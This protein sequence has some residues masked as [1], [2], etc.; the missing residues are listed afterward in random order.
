MP[1]HPVSNAAANA[2]TAG[3]LAENVTRFTRMLRAAGFAVGPERTIA[4]LDALQ[5]LGLAHRVRVHA[6]LASVL[7]D[8]H[9]DQPLFDAAFDA[10]WCAPPGADAA[11]PTAARDPGVPGRRAPIAASQRLSDALSAGVARQPAAVRDEDERVVVDVALGVSTRERLARRDFESMSAEEF[12]AATRLA[13]E[14]P[15]LLVPV[16]TR[17]RI[18]AARGAIDLH[19]VLRDS[20]RDPFAARLPRRR[21]QRRLPPLVVLCDV[22]GSMQRYSR[23]F[24]H[25]VHAMIR[26]HRQV[27][28]LTL[29]TRLT[30]I[31]HALQTRD[32]DDALAAVGSQVGDW[33][34]GTRLGPCL[35]E[36][37]RRWARRLL[38]GRST[39]LLLT[40]GLDRDDSG[41]LSFEAR[42]LRR[43]ARRTLWLNPLL[44]FAGFEPRAAGIRA[45]L[46]HVDEFLPAHDLDSLADLSNLLARRGERLR[47]DRH[48]TGRRTRWN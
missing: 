31:T 37:N 30:R 29:G 45:L 21:P 41:V 34:G 17:R 7:L 19:R 22:S 14:L 23:V 47:R 43:Y 27:E 24:L 44:R 6:A 3:H 28:A 35:R 33:A 5:L 12:R 32:V 1:P 10:F 8:R 42:R 15:N 18:D 2:G 25:W 46:P 4:A 20:A 48:A 38:A 40:D 11:T 26:H 16:S 9:E 36:F 39:V 13:A